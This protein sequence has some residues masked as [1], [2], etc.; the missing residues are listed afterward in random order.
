[1][2]KVFAMVL[3]IVLAASLLTGCSKN[4]ETKQ[5]GQEQ[6]KG[7]GDAASDDGIS[8]STAGEVKTTPSGYQLK[9]ITDKPVTLR[10]MWWGGDERNNATLEVIDQFMELYPNVTIEAEYGGNEGYKEKLVTQLYS[11]SA[12][13]LIQ[14]DPAWFFE[15]VEN[16]DYFIDYNEYKDYFDTS[17]FDAN[18]IKNYG[19]YNGKLLAVPT[20]TAGPGFIFNT[21]LADK[22]GLDYKTQITWD[23]LIEMGKQVQAY[24]PDLYL[25]NLDTLTVATEIIRPM[26][27]QKTGYPFIKDEEKQRSFS[28]EQLVDVLNY[29]K[30]LY[31]SGTVQ[32]AQESAPFY[33]ATDTNTKWIAGELVAALNYSSAVN[34]LIN[35]YNSEDKNFVAVQTPMPEDRQNDGYVNAPPQV[36]ATASTCENPEVAAAFWD[37]FFNSQEATLTLKDLR[38][39][40][41]IENNREILNSNGLINP[42]VKEA[43]D[44]TAPLNGVPEHGYTTGSEISQIIIDMVESIAYGNSTPEK[45]ADDSI[46]LIDDFLAQQQ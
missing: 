31:E 36:M 28:K 19:E 23:S 41:A 40:P 9:S 12:A 11:G 2:K 21:T 34:N 45:I 16:G 20:G 43:T 25:L 7:A 27:M 39:I 44:L 22:I 24:D 13:D 30:E 38:S 10:F 35:A 3:A 8:D 6:T 32:P 37:Y 46:A 5:T 14:C 17:V 18:M 1:M 26:I 4:G 42:V 29:V 33:N 15:L